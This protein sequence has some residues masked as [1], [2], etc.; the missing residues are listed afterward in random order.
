MWKKLLLIL[1]LLAVAGGAA[2]AVLGG[3]TSLYKTD[4]HVII[5]QSKRFLECVKFKEFGEASSFHSALDSKKADIPFLIE[6]LFKIKPEQLDIQ[7][8]NVLYG[9][10]DSSG[11]LGRTKSRCIVHVLNTKEIRKPEVILYWK[12]EG[13]KWFLKLKSSLE[14]NRRLR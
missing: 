10:I 11:V 2:W 9:E 8:V 13:G 3:W 6:R 4:K 12:K 5:Q 14:Q 1:A 7:E